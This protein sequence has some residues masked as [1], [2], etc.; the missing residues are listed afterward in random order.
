MKAKDFDI[1]GLGEALVEFN[2]TAP[3][4]PEYRLGMGGDTSNAIIAAARA[5][6]RTAYMGR[7]GGKD[8][9]GEMLLQTWQ[10]E[11]VDTSG[12]QCDIQANNGMYFVQHTV[13]GHRFSYARSQSAAARMQPGDLHCDLIERSRYLHVSGISLALSTSACD[14]VFAAMEHAKRVGTLVCLDANVRPNLWPLARA[15]AVLREAI[16]LCDV[17]LPGMDDMALLTGLQNPLDML[18]WIGSIHERAVVVLKMGHQGALLQEGGDGQRHTIASYSVQTVDATGAGDCFAGNFL[19]RICTG[20]DWLTAC[21]WA[22]AAAA[23]STTGWGAVGPL[24]YPGQVEALLQ[25][26]LTR[27]STQT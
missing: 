10:R 11:G 24:P 16:A 23:L 4:Q 13:E 15:R 6:V 17:F 20:D 2:Q 19:A 1:V 26:N 21:Q 18:D 25:S 27:G 8:G 12:M 5:G 22:S 9:F 7:Y 3:G 14:T